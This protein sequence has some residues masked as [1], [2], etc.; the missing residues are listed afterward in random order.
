[1]FTSVPESKFHSVLL[2][3]QPFLRS[4][5][6]WDKCTK[7]PQM[8]LNPTRSNIPHICVTSI[9][10]SP[11]QSVSFYDQL[12]LSYTPFWEKCTKWPRNDLEHYQVK[13]I[14]YMCCWYPWVL[15]FSPFCSTASRFWVTSHFETSVPNDPQMTLNPT[16]SNVPH[17]CVISI[18]ESQFSLSFTLWH[19]PFSSYRP[20][21]DKCTEWPQTLQGQRHTTYVLLVSPIPKFQSV[22]LYDQPFSRYRTFYTS[23]FTTMLNG[24]KKKGTK[25]QISQFF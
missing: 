22:L 15:N 1:M 6:F 13:C 19:N 23:P 4:R 17:I 7:S 8:T 12:F 18:H 10:N 25:F 3:D 9:P 2:Y 11:I 5:P 21:W 20:F 14:Q 24:Q 16:R